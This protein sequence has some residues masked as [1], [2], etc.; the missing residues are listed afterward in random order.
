MKHLLIL[1]DKN[2][3]LKKEFSK[4][5]KQMTQEG[6]ELFSSNVYSKLTN[7]VDKDNEFLKTLKGKTNVVIK[8]MAISEE[9]FANWKLI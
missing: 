4:V 8:S 9:E 2:E 5:H 6:Y 3:V 1:I 7:N